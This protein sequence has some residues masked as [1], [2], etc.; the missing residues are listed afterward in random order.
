MKEFHFK[1]EQLAVLWNP[2]SSSTNPGSIPSMSKLSS[3][4]ILSDEQFSSLL[5]SASILSFSTPSKSTLSMKSNEPIHITTRPSID[6]QNQLP[7]SLA[8][9]LTAAHERLKSSIQAHTETVKIV[10]NSILRRNRMENALDLV[11]QLSLHSI[12]DVS[13]KEIETLPSI[14][15][16]LLK[17]D[18]MTESTYTSIKQGTNSK[19]VDNV[20]TSG[21]VSKTVI[22]SIQANQL[23]FIQ[24]HKIQTQLLTPKLIGKYFHFSSLDILIIFIYMF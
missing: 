7:S 16:D 22:E 5:H 11:H 6:K 17:T 8:D 13:N 12:D 9:Q 20:M 10:S 15:L 4:F 24:I 3:Q 14:V 21:H 18:T 23:S 1:P 19:E 2:N